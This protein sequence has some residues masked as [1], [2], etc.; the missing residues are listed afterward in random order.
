MTGT[1]MGQKSY[2]PG[3]VDLQV[4]GYA[5]LDV[6]SD[7]VTPETIIDLT[8]E[9]WRQ[10]VTTYL[11]TIITASSE[12]IMHCL[13]AVEQARNADPLI[14]HS[15][16]GVHIEGPYISADEGP[17]GA[18]DQRWVRSPD[19]EE[20]RQW[21]ERSQGLIRLVTIAPE[22]NG[23]VPFAAAA[24]QLGVHVSI[25]HCS[26]THEQVVD[27]VNAGATLSTHLGN[28]T[29]PTLPR[30]PNHIWTQLAHDSLT[31]MVIPDGHHLPPEVLTVIIRAKSVNNCI[32]TSDSAALAGQPLG[33][34]NTPVGGQVTVEP[35]GRLT[36]TGSELLAGS[37]KNLR[38]CL[39]WATHALP[40]DRSSLLQMA[41]FNPAKI[42]GLT[43][44]ATHDSDTVT[45]VDDTPVEVAV[46][47]VTVYEA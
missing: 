16:P 34:Y 21:Q 7:A 43:E 22:Q 18:H 6:N 35:D 27:V 23:A 29:Y 44:R 11:P 47:G 1:F 38:E 31:S 5:G 14:A 40:F 8:H 39:T 24:A 26:P 13:E 17:R 32:F 36:L 45:I 25:G 4:N 9:Q 41:T 12:K 3:L 37:G 30:H 20:F 2:E 46:A 33:V 28:G 42:L 10:G 15:I 19:L